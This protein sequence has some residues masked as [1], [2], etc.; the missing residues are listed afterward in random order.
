MVL[1]DIILLVKKIAVGVV[2]FMVPLLLI[3]AILWLIQNI[4]FK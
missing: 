1:Q 2:L 3:A 4:F